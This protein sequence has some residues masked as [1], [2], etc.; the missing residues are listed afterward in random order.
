MDAIVT[1]SLQKFITD[2]QYGLTAYALFVR[3]EGAKYL[4]AAEDAKKEI[5]KNLP[6]RQDAG[7]PVVSPQFPPPVVQPK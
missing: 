6:Q 3:D 7:L 4:A 1:E 2:V 5:L